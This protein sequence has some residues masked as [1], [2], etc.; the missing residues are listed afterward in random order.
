VKRVLVT[1]IGGQVGH[2]I[3]KCLDGYDGESY[4]TDINDFPAGIDR[5]T[6]FAKVPLAVEAEFIPT[7]LL[8]CKD[9]GIT[10]LIPVNEQEILI[11]ARNADTFKSNGINVLSLTAEQLN[12]CSDKY[13]LPSV[14]KSFGLNAPD[15]YSVDEFAPDGG[16][17]I[18][19]LR[20]SY[21]S[22]LTHI[23]ETREQLMSIISQTKKEVV[24]QRYIPSPETEYT[25]GVFATE[26]EVRS[27]AFRRKLESGYTQFI[28][29]ADN[30]S[31]FLKM[32]ERIAE[33]LGIIGS[34][35]IQ[36][37]KNN[38]KYYIFEINPRIS[39]TV[40]FRHILGFQ[41]VRWWLA[42]SSNELLLPYDKKYTKAVGIREF[43]EK[44]ISSERT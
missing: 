29:L 28:E 25:V 26:K 12:I 39:G 35:N 20:N 27:I 2:G 23:F 36:L 44:I 32:A 37:R 42:H 16:Q 18:A 30:D 24:V 43:N 5:V 14:L 11:I 38:G 22:R 3:L 13:T 41:D 1:A 19:K 7:L 10:H 9:W 31:E 4:G 34:F 21:G 40:F 6:A 15:S 8:L 17:Y 33:N